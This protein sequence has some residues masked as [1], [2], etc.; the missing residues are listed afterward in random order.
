MMR[1]FALGLRFTFAKYKEPNHR[2]GGLDDPPDLK[3]KA[4]DKKRRY[5][6]MQ[7]YHLAGEEHPNFS[8]HPHDLA[9]LERNEVLLHSARSKP[10]Y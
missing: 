9:C 1:R 8:Q 2:L 4:L 6:A 10:E 5:D 7:H 3:N